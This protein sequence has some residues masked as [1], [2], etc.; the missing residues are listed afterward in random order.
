VSR[1]GERPLAIM[2]GGQLG[3]LM[4][5]AARNLG[6]RVR[7]L[8]PSADCPARPVV[9]DLVTAPF[10]DEIAAAW[11]ARGSAA[12]TFEIE[13]V[14]IGALRAAERHAPVRP[15]PEALEI[16]Q[17][18]A[19]QKA[20]LAAHGFPVG[21]HRVVDTGAALDEAIDAF[22]SVFVK[23][24]RGG[25][26]GRGQARVQSPAD[27]ADAHALL[28]S[29]RCV[30]E[31]A[32]DLE[33]EISLMVARNVAGEITV[34][35]PAQNHHE[36]QV[37]AWNLIPAPAAA[38]TLADAMEIARGIAVSLDVVGLLAV[39]LFELEGGRLYV[40]ELAPRPHNT[41]HAT[42]LACE[43]GQF[44][45]GV[46]AVLGLPLG[47]VALVRPTALGNLLGDLWKDGAP[48]FDR[49][50]AIPGVRLYLYEKRAAKPGRKMG[51]LLASA[52]T[53][54]EAIARVRAA[55]AAIESAE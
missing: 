2:G 38:G 7:V 36:H 55:I 52:S 44:E 25:Y 33:E 30:V 4:A 53:P 43:T 17:D 13:S 54:E 51:H 26:D 22:G 31:K 46:R 32:L 29:G 16:V 21:P 37:L 12:V 45:Q 49:A 35:P 14:G 27:R 5:M 48:R 24:C 50:L 40:N 23:S 34:Y 47:S 10:D 3:R 1:W 42:E 9:D 41:F 20:W 6:Q 39:E 15:R 19:A 18:R 28:A 8:D 11:L